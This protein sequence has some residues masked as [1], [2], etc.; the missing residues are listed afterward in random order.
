MIPG[1]E[2][3]A[4]PKRRAGKIGLIGAGGRIGS[5]IRRA[6][7]KLAPDIDVICASRTPQGRDWRRVDASDHD[8]I[9][10]FSRDC[11]LIIN[12]SGTRVNGE[13]LRIVDLGEEYCESAETAIY[14]CGAAPGILG[15]FPL[16][17]AKGFERVDRIRVDY[18]INEPMTLTA[19]KD[20]AKRYSTSGYS[21]I[22]SIT[23]PYSMPFFGDSVYSY[24]Y[25]DDESRGVEKLLGVQHSSWSMVRRSDDFEKILTAPYTDRDEFVR[26]LVEQSHVAQLGQKNEFVMTVYLDGES[27]GKK[28]ELTAFAQCDSPAALS[29]KAC[30]AAAIG[31]YEGV[32]RRGIYRLPFCDN[33][34]ALWDIF[35]RSDPFDT[36][37][38]Y[39]Y[40][41]NDG[42]ETDG[43]I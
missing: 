36:Y 25:S 10:E 31:L 42:A 17:L 26:K 27:E 2:S 5:E 6:L 8:S 11:V 9:S 39:P 7:K 13:G 38:L 16:V 37:K 12:A 34:L 29:G 4:C 23:T 35:M 18:L 22:G 21:N 43:E 32:L 3:T 30:A 41:L 19:A 40:A 15:L 33:R 14:G 1:R 24:P 28:T 20:M